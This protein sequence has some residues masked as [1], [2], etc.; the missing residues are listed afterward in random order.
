MPNED[1]SQ[2]FSPLLAGCQ[3]R[4][5]FQAKDYGAAR[6][7]W[8]AGTVER[9]R[10]DG[11]YDI[12][13]DDKEREEHVPP[14][15]VKQREAQPAPSNSTA[16]CPASTGK[17]KAHT[18]GKTKPP[19]EGN[20]QVQ[21][22]R[23][24]RN[25]T[26]SDLREMGF[27]ASLVEA[28]LA[29]SKGNGR[30]ALD[31]LTRSESSSGRVK[32]SRQGSSSNDSPAVVAPAAGA[33]ELAQSGFDPMAVTSGPATPVPSASPVPVAE[34]KAPV[35]ARCRNQCEVAPACPQPTAN[36][37]SA[38]LPIE[39]PPLRNADPLRIDSN[40]FVEGPGMLDAATCSEIARISMAGAKQIS[41]ASELDLVAKS[42]SLARRIKSS[43]YSDARL[44]AAVLHLYST[45]EFTIPTLK[46]LEAEDDAEAQIPHAD[47]FWN[48]ELF[49]VLQVRPAQRPTQAVVYDSSAAYPT[50]LWHPC[51]ACG[52]YLAVPDSVARKRGHLSGSFSCST[53]GM[54]C[55][56]T[57]T[58]ATAPEEANDER[59]QADA[60][61]TRDA[62][63]QL[64]FRPQETISCMRPLGAPQPNV[65]D[66]V[67]G[68][69]TLVHRGPG[70]RGA[71]P[72]A[73]LRRVLFF[74]VRPRFTDRALNAEGTAYDPDKQIHAAWLLWACS[75]AV[76]EETRGRVHAAYK[77]L[78]HDLEGFA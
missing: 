50:N 2:T 55:E 3:V 67:V 25:P 15:F 35:N 13:Y 28:A 39:L 23:V 48:R 59:E 36:H 60:E 14:Q 37:S 12:L 9:R 24:A 21:A 43:L 45:S 61:C 42:T 10:A 76:D 31:E 5:R 16:A 56:C 40:G 34:A 54:T 68:L 44:R 6:T 51:N 74:T 27:D 22:P 41:N 4:A 30:L 65:G 58:L 19:G 75:N 26:A 46:V 62:F 7:S 33:S 53:L 18:C 70:G 20:A 57:Q 69:P 1:A 32:R 77:K 8:Y 73:P 49:G 64:L 38:T 47:D 78:G 52:S 71:Q 72:G 63:S 17:K 29:R 66:A 11:T